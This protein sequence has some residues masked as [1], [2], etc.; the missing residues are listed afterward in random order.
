MVK[1]GQ[2]TRVWSILNYRMLTHVYDL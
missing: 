2:K 1:A